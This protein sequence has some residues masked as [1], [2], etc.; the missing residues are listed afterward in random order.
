MLLIGRW[1]KRTI[2]EE[3]TS[4]GLRKILVSARKQMMQDVMKQIGLYLLAFWSTYILSMINGVLEKITGAPDAN[5]LIIGNCMSSLQ[6]AILTMVYFS[7]QRMT[8]V[9]KRFPKNPRLTERRK[10]HI[11]VSMIRNNAA[12]RDAMSD[13]TVDEESEDEQC[14]FFI[15][16]GA[17]SD[18]SPWGTY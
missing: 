3:E 5:L 6:G 9:S 1:I 12:A 14:T 18:D 7:L 16:D 11:T 2:K 4:V 8:N 10:H 17:P 15:F 13:G